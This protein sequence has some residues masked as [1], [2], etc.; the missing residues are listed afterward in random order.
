MIQ[1]IRSIA[2]LSLLQTVF[3]KRSADS[4]HQSYFSPSQDGF[5]NTH[6]LRKHGLAF[7]QSRALRYFNSKSEQ[8]MNVVAE[9]TTRKN[10]S[11]NLNDG[12]KND[13]EKDND[14]KVGSA[15][16]DGIPDSNEFLGLPSWARRL[17]TEKTL[18]KDISQLS[19]SA[20]TS[21]DGP[22][23][24]TL[25]EEAAKGNKS[26]SNFPLASLINVEALLMASGQI[27]TESESV[28]DSALL[29][30]MLSTKNSPES[31]SVSVGENGMQNVQE[32]L[33]WDNFMQGL[34]RNVKDVV[35]KNNDAV[36]PRSDLA[37]ST[38]YVLNQATQ[39]IESFLND[40]TTSFSQERVQALILAA[41][42]GLSV[43]QNADNLKSIIDKVV[44]AA[45]KIAREQGVDVSEAAAQARATTKYTTEFLRVANGV[46]LSGYVAGGELS[47]TQSAN[48]AR[49]MS[50]S[51]DADDAKL[52]KPLFHRFRSV[53]RV[54]EGSFDHVSRTGAEM[55]K[56]AGAI[57]QDTLPIIHGLGHAMV[58]NGTSA[59]VVWMVT[60]SIAYDSEF[61]EISDDEANAPQLVRTITL[62]GFD[63]S[64]ESVDRERLI[65]RLCNADRVPLSSEFE[66]LDVH[67]GLMTV[68][69]EIY[70]DLKPLIDMVGPNHKIVLNGHSI[71]GAVSNLIL[72]LMTLERGNIHV[73][74]KIKRVFTFGSPP[75]AIYE[76]GP[77]VDIVPSTNTCAILERLGL[78]SDI[79][80]GF[81]EPWVSLSLQYYESLLQSDH[82][83]ILVSS[84]F[85]KQ[86][87][88]PRLFS[89]IDAMY[90]LI[91]DLGDDGVTLYA[92]GPPRTLRPITRAILESWENWPRFRD[93]NKPVMSQDF[94]SIG[95]CFLLMPDFGRYLTDRLVTVNVNAYPVDE[96]LRI[97]SSELYDALEETFPLDTFSISLVPTA[98][99]SF[100]H[101]FFP[102]YS[103]GF[104][105]YVLKEDKKKKTNNASKQITNGSAQPKKMKTLSIAK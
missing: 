22:S 14:A 92:T 82:S 9:T 84:L 16:K 83:N 98:I 96:V 52:S 99:R 86:D 45:E 10:F 12:W 59:D 41:T 35:E 19:Q 89:R 29:M 51:L 38:D 27:P 1:I 33:S 24:E 46:L 67:K 62:R 78:P 25:G 75:I 31:S 34:R 43:D 80:H 105:A 72:M 5:V 18:E 30:D 40:A 4:L 11:F 37:L 47:L 65:T 60:D 28:S 56:L 64:D 36:G 70:E 54:S 6:Y 104:E 68:A 53:Q 81:I 55:A 103:D 7:V 91:G 32:D 69:K 8:V 97:S 49:E 95:T 39:R 20:T 2:L 76:A 26:S 21:N 3:S 58:A 85:C 13:K 48:Y 87:P 79:V 23:G 15:L 71:G 66:G 77:Q 61:Q 90:P 42:R 101:H 74:D 88:I 44:L 50:I 57:Y 100:I 63:A 93:E 102:A 73:Q 94:Q 17:I